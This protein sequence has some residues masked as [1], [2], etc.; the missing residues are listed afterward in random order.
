MAVL[1]LV[2]GSMGCPPVPVPDCKQTS[3][4]GKHSM[5][6]Q[7]TLSYYPQKQVARAMAVAN[8]VEPYSVVF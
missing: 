2:A 3:I 6:F 4:T 8:K 1:P 7:Q 5:L